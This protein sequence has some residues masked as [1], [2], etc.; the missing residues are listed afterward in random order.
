MST[1]VHTSRLEAARLGALL[2]ALRSIDGELSLPLVLALVAVASQPGI[3][4]N[5]L[6]KCI[7]VPQQTASR[8]VAILQGRYQLANASVNPFVAKP[9]LSLQVSTNDPRRRAL[10]VT[11]QGNDILKEITNQLYT[12]ATHGP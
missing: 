1:E 2:T 7:Q 9:L 4:I 10:F 12:E 3:S 8:Y 11:Q 6:A 5:G